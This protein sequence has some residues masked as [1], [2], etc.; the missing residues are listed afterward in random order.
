MD[1]AVKYNSLYKAVSKAKPQA[2]KQE[3]QQVTNRL[4]EKIKGN[5]TTY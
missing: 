2:T 4:W 3:Q 5:E 1:N